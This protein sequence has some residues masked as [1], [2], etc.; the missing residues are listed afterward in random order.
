M[1]YMQRPMIM[2]G[3]KAAEP[4]IVPGSQVSSF[5]VLSPDLDDGQHDLGSGG[6]QSHQS[7][8]SHSLV[9][10]LDNNNLSLAGPWVLDRHFLLLCGDHFDGLHELVRSDSNSNEKVDHESDVEQTTSKS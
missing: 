8:V 4:T 1:T 10:D 2:N 6:T 7:Q 5:E 9:P 3:L